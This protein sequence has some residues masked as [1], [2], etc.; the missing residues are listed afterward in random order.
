MYQPFGCREI[1]GGFFLYFFHKKLQKDLV[2]SKNCIIFVTEKESKTIKKENTMISINFIYVAIALMIVC[3][4][5]DEIKD[6]IKGLF[7][8]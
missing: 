2:V 6:K 5:L 7:K 3:E 1:S 4:N 8:K